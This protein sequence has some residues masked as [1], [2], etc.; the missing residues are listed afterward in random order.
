MNKKKYFFHFAGL[1]EGQPIFLWPSH[2]TEQNGVL[3]FSE[4]KDSD[5]GRYSCVATS[6]QGII[7]VTIRVDVI[8]ENY[9]FN[10]QV[11]LL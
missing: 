8:G 11:F 9:L 1:Q 4:V 3:H 10:L 5:A 2:I 7:N 6:T